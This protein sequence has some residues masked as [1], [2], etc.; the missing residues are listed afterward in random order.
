ME[1]IRGKDTLQAYLVAD[2]ELTVVEIREYLAGQ[3]P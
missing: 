1:D 3:F 2:K